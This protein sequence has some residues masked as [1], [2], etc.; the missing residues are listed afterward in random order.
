MTK[1]SKPKKP[2]NSLDIDGNINGS[3]IM[4]GDG[5]T[6]IQQPAPLP[7][8]H[9]ALGSI[10]PAN[11][12]GYVHRGQIEDDIRAALRKGGA[13]AIVGLHAPGGTGK[14]EL[15]NCIA[16]EVRDGKFGFESALWLDVNEKTPQEVLS[17]GLRKCGLQAQI[18]AT[19]ADKKAEW[20]YFLLNHKLLVIFDDVRENAREGLK[21]ILPPAP[22]AA[23]ITSRIQQMAGV[24]QFALDHMQPEQARE[25]F[26]N[27]LGEEVA[28][29][30]EEMVF[31]LAERCKYNPLALEI[32]SRRIQQNARF[33]SNPIA[34]YYEKAAK[35]FE[36]LE[37]HGDKRW[38]MTG[39]FDLSYNDLT[40]ADQRFFRMLSVF[41][42]TGFSPNAAAH[43][44]ETDEEQAGEALSR[45][46]NLSLVIPVT[47]DFERFRLHDLLDEYAT[48]KLRDS[49]EEEK[50]TSALADWLIQ[51]FEEHYADD[52]SSAPEVGL[53]FA[54]LAKT[55]EWALEN[56]KGAMLASL[57]TKPRNWLYNYFRELANWQ[58][59]LETS[60]K[61]GVEDKRLQANVLQANVLQAIG[62]VQQ[63]RDDRDA[64]LVSYNEALKLF[65][66]IG[67]KLGEANVL[68]TLS[69]VAVSKGEIEIAEKQMAEIINMRRAIGDIYSEGADY[70]NFAFT[71]LNYGHKEKAREYALKARPIFVR[72]NLP[73][74]VEMMDKV[75]SAA[76][77]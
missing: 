61:I 66:E 53:E 31:K 6:I 23:L 26:V 47:G 40:E 34:K 12:N 37:M 73:A 60:L 67:D 10:P 49:G 28:Q 46:I 33:T 51:L 75:I 69:R 8:T 21:A 65:K 24:K 50:A 32:A 45:F 57:A 25:L 5:N 74:I 9:A 70:A 39:V 56:R 29:A 71:L 38:N 27:S 3:N 22:C 68:A 1:S 13:S 35:R 52:F 36:E 44:W 7:E 48:P 58:R 41:A 62:D 43:V 17:E 64:A 42:P 11:P 19:E 77:G 59:W 14:T 4:V 76:D 20:Q 72:I 63:F 2:K 18:N 30:E 16:Q 54:N 55:A 15:A